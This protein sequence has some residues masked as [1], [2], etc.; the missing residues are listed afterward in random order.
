MVKV[1]KWNGTDKDAGRA[2]TDAERDRGTG[3][4]QSTDEDNDDH[5]DSPKKEKKRRIFKLSKV[6][7]TKITY[8]R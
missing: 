5:D 1:G 3:I 4:N 6:H 7:L 8:L 2:N